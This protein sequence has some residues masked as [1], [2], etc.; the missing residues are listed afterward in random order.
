MQ[1]MQTKPLETLDD[2]MHNCIDDCLQC[3][4]AALQCVLHCPSKG[5]AHAEVGLLRILLDCAEICRTSVDFMQ[6]GSE[7]HNFT[8]GVCSKICERCAD[9]CEA[10]GVEDE[11]MRLCVDECRRCAE[12]CQKM[13]SHHTPG[14]HAS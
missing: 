4:D 7:Q 8:C 14:Q 9:A 12:S 2:Y 5:G 1:A 3:R 13:A 6:R 10:I 11:H